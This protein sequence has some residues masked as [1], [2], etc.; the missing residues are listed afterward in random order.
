MNFPCPIVLEECGCSQNP[1]R[2]L[3][4]LAPDVP[5]F[6]GIDYASLVP[7]LGVA[8][9]A[10]SCVGLIQ[11]TVS[12]ADANAAAARAAI[13][14]ATAT[15]ETP[16]FP[17]ARVPSPPV[18]P[19]TPTR[20][21]NPF[22]REA[23][24]PQT[25]STKCPDGNSFSFTT[26]AGMFEGTGNT[27]S[28]AQTSADAQ[29]LSYAQVQATERMV[30]LGGITSNSCVNQPYQSVIVASGNLVSPFPGVNHWSIIFGGLP[31][32]LSLQP[33]VPGPGSATISG[34]PT[35]TGTNVFLVR[36]ADPAG[37][38]MIKA[39]TITILGVTPATLPDPQVGVPYNQQLTGA[40]MTAPVFSVSSGTLPTG[41]TMTAAG[42]IS[43]TP[44]TVQTS[45]FNVQAVDSATGLICGQSYTLKPFVG[46]FKFNTNWSNPNNIINPPA[47]GTGNYTAAGFVVTT[48]T[49]GGGSSELNNDSQGTPQTMP[50]L[51]TA[52]NLHLNIS[53]AMIQCSVQVWQGGTL[54]L[55]F[56]PSPPGSFS[57]NF[58]IPFNVA[59]S[60]NSGVFIKTAIVNGAGLSSVVT[61]T[62]TPS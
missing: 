18:P 36:F 9:N 6:T 37:D 34:T 55:N 28:Q 38:V 21:G 19:P 51:L 26:P 3:S 11:S 14:C 2:N 20:G 42:L 33:D 5:K 4:S 13:L 29:A 16:S 8:W 35:A 49:A 48:N 53:A 22:W 39:Y 52:C 62:L 46:P 60:G 44:T 1:V 47:T 58:D 23:N 41:L 24:S 30:C 61:G 27:R 15:W 56:N 10:F 57:G 45:T 25:A 12:Q 43:G 50:C 59:A 40:Q 7:P 32:G 31:A 17:G 54:L